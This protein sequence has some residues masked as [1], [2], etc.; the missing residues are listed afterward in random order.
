MECEI[1]KWNYFFF[2]YKFQKKAN[3]LIFNEE[4]GVS[5]TNTNLKIIGGSIANPS[6]WPS[7]ALIKACSPSKSCYQCGGTLIDRST[8]LTAAH[9]FYGADYTYTVYLGLYDSSSLKNADNKPALSVTTT[10]AIRVIFISNLIKINI[11]SHYVS[12]K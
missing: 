3:F 8:V 9:C 4:C 5:T 10:K 7:L 1:G 2:N 11:F 12:I 6:S